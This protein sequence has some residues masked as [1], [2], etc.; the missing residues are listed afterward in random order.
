MRDEKLF[1]RNVEL[2]SR[3]FP[4]QA[5]L[6]PYTAVDDYAFTETAQGELNLARKDFLYHSPD[7]AQEEA[8]KWFAACSLRKVN[9]LYVFG[10]GLG[11]GYRAAKKWLKGNKKRRL[12][13]LEDELPVLFHLF[14]TENGA[15]LLQ[16]SQVE[17]YYFK[18]LKDAEEVFEPLYW[19]HAMQ[20]LAMS[21][22]DSYAVSKKEFYEELSHK[23]AF[24]AA[25]KNAL[26]DEYLRYG[27]AFYINFY[28]NMLCLSS[29]YLGNDLFGKFPKVPAI[30]CGAGPSLN[31]H[32][33]QLKGLCDKAVVFAGG[34]AMNALNSAGILPHF[35]AGI[36]PNSMQF[37]RLSTNEAFEIPYFYRA[38][39]FHDAFL[40]V[41]GPRLYVTGTG[42]YDTSDWFEKKLGITSDISLD[43]GHNVINFCLEIANAMG[44]NPII[45]LGMDLGFTEMKAYASGIEDNV[46]VSKTQLLSTEEMDDK[47]LLKEDVYGRPL[48]TLWKWIAE[49]EWIG[50]YAKE[51]PNLL[52]VN[53][54]EGGLGLPGVPN[55]TLK[56]STER[57][58]KRPIELP[59]RIHTEVANSAMPQV[60]PRKIKRVFKELED[61]L[62][63]C[64]QH[65]QALLDDCQL[66]M[67][68][69]EANVPPKEVK[70]GGRAALA[71]IELGEEEAYEAVL[72]MFNMVYARLLNGELHDL[73]TR[74][75]LSEKKRQL[76]KLKLSQRKLTFLSEVAMLNKQLIA[77]VQ[78]EH[79][80]WSRKR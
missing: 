70:Q 14:Q 48:Y 62:G 31:Q 19:N 76:G 25:T 26:L 58:L 43:E 15:A 64:I 78:A 16:D 49:A 44:C 36:D 61:S 71:E 50:D 32:L 41:H 20:R 73:S 53:S 42:G 65:L 39:M 7:G 9:V 77:F 45:F 59:N 54:T 38:R 37:A 51:H 56:E 69:L 24:D 46:E 10:V 17:L 8:D 52:L 28:A 18:S 47:A 55:Q 35:G 74:P 27:G 3:F 75:R 33:E 12:V 5:W 72:G 11:Y 4:R 34:S 1:H 6:L 13:F 22:L 60:T 40:A 68:Q 29:S 80:K 21:A 67:Q 2:W 66:Q 30:I 23:I 79:K 57:Y 63:R